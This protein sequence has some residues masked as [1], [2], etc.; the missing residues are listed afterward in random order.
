MA[1]DLQLTPARL[2]WAQ[3]R[4]SIVGPLYHSP[5][6]PGELA[7]R[8]AELACKEWL[9]PTTS[10]A[11]SFAAK[12]IERWYYVA[13]S[14]NDPILA[15]ARKTPCHA[16]THRSVTAQQAA[17]LQ[18]QY[19]DHPGWAHKLHYDTIV[20]LSKRERPDLKPVPSY[21]TVTRFMRDRGW[22]KIKRRRLSKQDGGSDVVARETRSFEVPYVNGLWH[23]D[24]HQGR[25]KVLTASGEWRVPY[26]L[27]VLDDCSRLCC[28]AQW[29]LDPENTEN[30]IHGL[31]QAIQKRGLPRATLSDNGAAMKAAETRAGL[32]RLGIVSYL[33]LPYSPEQNAKQ[34]NF[35]CRFEDRLMPQLEGEP[36][37]TIDLLNRATQAWVELEYHQSVHSELK[38]TP[39]ER[40]MEGPNVARP[41][42][43]SDDLRSAF[44][45]NVRRKQRRSDGTVTVEGVRFEVPSAY[46]TLTS[47]LVRVARWDLSS[48][49]LVDPH[50]E[51]RLAKLWP[52]DKAKNANRA[53]KVLAQSDVSPAAS[54]RKPTGIAPL[55][56]QQMADY[57]ATGLPPGYLTKGPR[58][59][60]D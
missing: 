5:P 52:L 41:S 26:V 9:H 32:T 19:A 48:V 11:V 28:H 42:P 40:Y 23:F 29:Y 21:A 22:T 2:R 12:T 50:T 37:L 17:V 18:E 25:R 35:W 47:L 24:F 34:E 43:N 3:L 53:R 20:G 39:I 57:A 8:F 15:L 58:E 1:T 27:G 49:D 44:R 10:E 13:R 51:T 45:M 46:R 54:R 4:F 16:G 14:E 7:S 33:T 56:R 55:L 36:V 38:K 59:R 30:L 31:S 6:N 60:E